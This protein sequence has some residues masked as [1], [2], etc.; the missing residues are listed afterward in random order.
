MDKIKIEHYIE[1]SKELSELLRINSR[2]TIINY[3]E[4]SSF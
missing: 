4:N 3:E 1:F 2:K